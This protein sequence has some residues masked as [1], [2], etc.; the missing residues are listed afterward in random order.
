MF[1]VQSYH[2][3][4][5]NS[6]C[7]GIFKGIIRQGSKIEYSS[8]GQSDQV[9]AD[10]VFCLC[11]YGGGH[12]EYDKSS[13]PHCADYDHFVFAQDKDEDKQSSGSQ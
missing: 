6:D 11:G 12:C 8:R 3:K 4:D 5:G 9:P 13:G 7:E 10:N 1:N 2:K